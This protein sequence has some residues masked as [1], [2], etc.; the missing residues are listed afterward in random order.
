MGPARGSG[1][2]RVRVRAGAGGLA[3]APPSALR[4]VWF[5]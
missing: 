5:L 3:W 4:D 1:Q 2:V